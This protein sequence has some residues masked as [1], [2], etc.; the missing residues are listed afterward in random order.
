MKPGQ[1]YPAR[2][3]TP[4][5]HCFTADK[6]ASR[7]E[8]SGSPSGSQALLTRKEAA[9]YLRVEVQ[10]LAKWA[11]QGTIKLPVVKLGRLVRYHRQDL[12]TLMRSGSTAGVFANPMNARKEK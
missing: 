10:T 6:A 4:D 3:Q 1:H 11:C 2:V 7:P 9:K 5:K 8:G 12:E